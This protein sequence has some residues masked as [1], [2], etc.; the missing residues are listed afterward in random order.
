MRLERAE[1][2]YHQFYN[3]HGMFTAWRKRCTFAPIERDVIV[4]SSYILW[5]GAFG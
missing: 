5:K 3:E 1:V 2:A 4:E